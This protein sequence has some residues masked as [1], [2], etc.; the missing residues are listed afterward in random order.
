VSEWF[1]FVQDS[2]AYPEERKIIW[3]LEAARECAFFFLLHSLGL[4]QEKRAEGGGLGVIARYDR[5]TEPF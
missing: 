2:W 4:L 3:T 5:K 1:V